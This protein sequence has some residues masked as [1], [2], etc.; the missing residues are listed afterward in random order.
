LTGTTF[1]CDHTNAT[2]GDSTEPCTATIPE[3]DAL[4]AWVA[5]RQNTAIAKGRVLVHVIAD[6]ST[7]D[8]HNDQP[9][10]MDGHGVISAAHLRDLIDR[11]DTRIRP[12]APTTGTPG[13]SGAALSLP[14]HLPSNPYR[15]ST[16]LDVFVRARDGYCTAP[17]C[18]QPAS[19]CDL[20][21]VTEYDHDHPERGGQT[22][23]D[24]LAAKCR[25]HHLLKTFGERW[26]DDQ[27]RGPRGRLISEVITPEG[28]RCP[29]PAETNADLFLSLDE[30][31]WHRPGLDTTAPSSR[32]LDYRPPRDRTKAKHARRR[33]E[34][35]ANR[36]H[37]LALEWEAAE[38]DYHRRKTSPRET[39]GDPPF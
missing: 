28:I 23:P 15:P 29:G 5:D 38:H 35:Q 7:V 36:A 13:S 11:D 12:L 9:A 27:Y 1:T 39:D 14:T 34:R 31:R 32:S 24:G 25:L 4:A 6:Q 22:T 10:F 26:V 3:P 21:H 37:R 17:G 30:I 20:D 18:D 2:T 19:R 33:A 8:C 16:A